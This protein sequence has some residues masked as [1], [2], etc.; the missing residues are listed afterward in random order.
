MHIEIVLA[1]QER[2]VK[3]VQ[4][5]GSQKVLSTSISI[6]DSRRPPTSTCLF[7]FIVLVIWELFDNF[8]KSYTYFEKLNREPIVG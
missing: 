7:F 2:E 1:L 5:T 4:T 3:V 8:E 6:R